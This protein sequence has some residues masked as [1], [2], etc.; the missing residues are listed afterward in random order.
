MCGTAFP[1]CCHVVSYMAQGALEVGAG[2]VARALDGGIDIIGA[3][4]EMFN[5]GHKSNVVSY[6]GR[7]PWL[8]GTA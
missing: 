3:R 6:Y 4:I 1:E 2:L 5:R 7:R 8:D